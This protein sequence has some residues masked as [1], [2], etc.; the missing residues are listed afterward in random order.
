MVIDGL[1]AVK[2]GGAR[3]RLNSVCIVE[4][5]RY[6]R[7]GMVREVRHVPEVTRWFVG[8]I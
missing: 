4:C 7:K 8:S 5:G 6:T 3:L 2:V 1:K